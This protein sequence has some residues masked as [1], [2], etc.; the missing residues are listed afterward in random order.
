MKTGPYRRDV[1]MNTK[2]LCLFSW[3]R[4]SGTNAIALSQVMFNGSDGNKGCN[5]LVV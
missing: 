2:D 5:A 1:V 4:L 3:Q